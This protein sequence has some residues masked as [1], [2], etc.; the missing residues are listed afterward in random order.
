MSFIEERLDEIDIVSASVI[1]DSEGIIY[2][3]YFKIKNFFQIEA[4][5]YKIDRNFIFSLFIIDRGLFARFY[6]VIG[7]RLAERIINLP[8]KNHL[9]KLN[10]PHT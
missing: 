1:V 6:Q 10:S 3:T 9:K 4:E 8:L 2:S 5:F 7:T